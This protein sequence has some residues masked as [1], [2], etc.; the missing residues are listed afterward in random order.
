M[1]NFNFIDYFVGLNLASGDREGDGD[2]GTLG[3]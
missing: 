3:L 2:S 1:F